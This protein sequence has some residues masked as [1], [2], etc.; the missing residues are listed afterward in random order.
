MSRV[1]LITGASSGVG[2]SL[3][4]VLAQRGFHVVATMRN[5]DKRG[6]LDAA[7]EAAGVEI[8]VRRLDVSE[9]ESIET[10]VSGVIAETGRIDVLVN[11]AGVGFVRSTEQATEEEIQWVLNVNLMGVIRCTKAVI[12]HMREAEAGHIVTISSVGGL[13]GQPFNEI[14]CAS[15]F[16]VEGYTEAMA[17]YL[18][19]TFG[20]HFTAV[21][22][23]GIQS[24]FATSALAQF[25]ETGGMRDDPYL[26]AFQQYLGNAQRRMA[27]AAESAVYQTAD[28]VSAV[29][30]DCIGADEP[31]VRVRTSEWA[32]EL[33]RPKTELDPTG[34]R[35]PK[36]VY[37]RF[38]S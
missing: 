34:S 33:C 15:K 18:T 20:I 25:Q 31:P 13:V 38:M 27:D 26:P 28:E 30:A 10:C 35:L 7:A 4:V 36:I 29:I 14:Y 24:E 6:D 9:T 12:P 8:D 11:N 17:S 3:S 16:A 5:L 19:P 22:P 2:L 32:E 1:A 23:G 37:E 21:E